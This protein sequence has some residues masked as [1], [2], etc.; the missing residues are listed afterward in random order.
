MNTVIGA[1]GENSL[2]KVITN[3]A[4]AIENKAGTYANYVEITGTCVVCKDLPS[5][6]NYVE[7]KSSECVAWI[8]TAAFTFTSLT[9]DESYSLNIPEDSEVKN[10]LPEG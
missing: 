9:V 5:N 3:A 4:I 7:A 1:S 10:Y 6:V 2:I 8:T